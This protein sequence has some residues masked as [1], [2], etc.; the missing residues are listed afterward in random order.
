M[1]KENVLP[2]IRVKMRNEKDLN[3]KGETSLR[4]V[5]RLIGEGKVCRATGFTV[6]PNL[7]DKKN[8][9]ALGN[10][11]ECKLLNRAIALKI[12]EFESYFEKMRA[13]EKRIT[14][15]SVNDFFHDRRFDDFFGYFDSLLAERK[16][17]NEKSTCVKDA[18][19]R[20]RLEDYAIS[21][22]YRNLKFV[23]IT[24]EFLKGFDKFLI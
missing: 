4:Y 20:N 15:K 16:S 12:V 7:W 11:E 21:V 22:G 9:K 14:L 10:S 24:L 19:C 23:D 2:T 13:L 1:R 8:R 3:A 18:V 5:V 6:K 17:V